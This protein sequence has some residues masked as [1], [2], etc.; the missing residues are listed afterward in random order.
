V[1]G[2]SL[3]LVF[4]VRGWVVLVARRDSFGFRLFR[5]TRVDRIEDG[6]ALDGASCDVCEVPQRLVQPRKLL[7]CGLPDLTDAHRKDPAVERLLARALQ[8]LDDLGGIL[9]SETA[10]GLIGAE[11]E[12]AEIV[13]GQGEEIERSTT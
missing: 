2:F 7:R 13:D 9:L 10:H 3:L 5:G 4:L 11:V 8:R 12:R 6:R 1:G